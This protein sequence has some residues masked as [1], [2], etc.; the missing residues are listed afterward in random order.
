MECQQHLTSQAGKMDAVNWICCSP[1][2]L[3]LSHPRQLLSQAIDDEVPICMNCH[4][5]NSK[6]GDCTT[7]LH[8]RMASWHG[9][10]ETRC[11]PNFSMHHKA[12]GCFSVKQFNFAHPLCVMLRWI[13]EREMGHQ[14]RC[15]MTPSH[16]PTGC[17]YTGPL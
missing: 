10:L 4:S 14:T 1:S 9:S 8:L 11:Y 12:H 16:I 15:T 2:Q 5:G 3:C 6:P 13:A 17:S 7:L